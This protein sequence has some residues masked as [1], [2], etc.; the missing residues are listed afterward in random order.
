MTIRERRSE[1]KDDPTPKLCIENR[2]LATPSMPSILAIDPPRLVR[3]Q[4]GEAFDLDP[5]IL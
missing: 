3:P 5:E 4:V 2:K 1:R